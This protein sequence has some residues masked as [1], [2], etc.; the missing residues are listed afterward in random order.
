[1]SVSIDLGPPLWD[2]DAAER[3]CVEC[4][5]ALPRDAFPPRG[6]LRTFRTSPYFTCLGCAALAARVR[7]YG[8]SVKD[9][10]ELVRLQEGACAICS[11]CP[12][13]PTAL[14]IDH[15]HATGEVRGLLCG[16]CNTGIGHLGDDADRIAR[17]AE[18]VRANG[19]KP[20]FR[21]LT[22]R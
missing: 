7:A 6:S 8:I 19:T 16:G 17:A 22:T 11:T 18:Y 5:R 21:V 12:E 15:N 3:T 1:M 14:H 13:D 20:S 4:D 9:F 2:W 10:W